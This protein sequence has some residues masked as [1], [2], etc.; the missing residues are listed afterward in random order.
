MPGDDR[1]EVTLDTLH[2]DLAALRGETRDGFA[3]LKATLITGFRNLPSREQ[4][5]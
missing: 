4:S 3:D 5:E 1:E 2:D